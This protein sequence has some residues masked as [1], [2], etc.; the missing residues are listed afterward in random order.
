MSTPLFTSRVDWTSWAE[1]AEPRQ[2]E[3]CGDVFA[4]NHPRRR[5]CGQDACPGRR[6]SAAPRRRRPT[7]R[8]QAAARA[9]GVQGLLGEVL[10]EV[11]RDDL[12]SLDEVLKAAGKLVAAERAGAAGPEKRRLVVKL[13]AAGAARGLVLVP[14]NVADEYTD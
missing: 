3:G 5:F 13:L 9:A 12:G 14:P 8:A 4:P 11:H 7:G 10:V 6:P 2:C 1:H